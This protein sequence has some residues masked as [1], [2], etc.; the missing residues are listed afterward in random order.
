MEFTYHKIRHIKCLEW[1]LQWFLTVLYPPSPLLN[2]STFHFPQKEISHLLKQS[3]SCFYVFKDA[4]W[5]TSLVVQCLSAHLMVQGPLVQPWVWELR[6]R[7][8]QGN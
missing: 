6:S 5:G 4:T 1:F 3:I 8:L 7:M 2:S